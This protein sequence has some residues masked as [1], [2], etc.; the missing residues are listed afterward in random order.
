MDSLLFSVDVKYQI[1]LSLNRSEV[2]LRCPY[3][4]KQSGMSLLQQ[5]QKKCPSLRTETPNSCRSCDP[6]WSW[7]PAQ[8]TPTLLAGL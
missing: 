5:P 3:Q 7:E 6:E 8:T 1:N 4:G 2:E